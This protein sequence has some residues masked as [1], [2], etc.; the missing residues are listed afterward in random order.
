MQLR[1]RQFE[2]PLLTCRLLYIRHDF[3]SLLAGRPAPSEIQIE[4]ASLY[5]PAMLSRHGH[6]RGHRERSRRPAALRATRLAGRPA[7]RPGRQR[8]DH[9]LR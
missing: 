2:D 9:R 6:H 7:G 3:W 5:L 8:A 1:T 4:G